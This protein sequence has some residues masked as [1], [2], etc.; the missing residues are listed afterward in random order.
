MAR[1]EAAGG[2]VAE[3]GDR[4]GTESTAQEGKRVVSGK[5]ASIYK[6]RIIYDMYDHIYIYTHTIPQI[7]GTHTNIQTRTYTHV[8][9]HIETIHGHMIYVRENLKI[10]KFCYVLRCRPPD[11]GRG[12]HAQQCV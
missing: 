1:G 6:C 2:T 5:S 11:L 10:N 9:H 12:R 3:G 7:Y 4:K 8:I